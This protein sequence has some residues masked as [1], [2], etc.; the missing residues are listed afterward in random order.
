MKI[1]CHII[2]TFGRVKPKIMVMG[3]KGHGKDTVCEMLRDNH[4]YKFE[5]SSYFALHNCG[6]YEILKGRHGYKTA[7]ECY[8][9]RDNHR[10]E[11]HQLIKDFNTQDLAK[12]GR[13]IYAD[14]DIYCG[15]RDDEE[16]GELEY[17]GLIDFK[18]WVDSSARGKPSENRDSC[19]VSAEDS[20]IIL[21]NF[22]SLKDL[23][24]TISQIVE[25]IENE[26]NSF[27]NI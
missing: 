9:D 23:K 2:E 13:M 26:R 14:N 16:L 22:G 8:L 3:Y 20:D 17:E 6:L 5:S 1:D 18:I 4:G 27:G 15:I 24:V 10:P 19:K 21:E 7:Q 12:M 11:W 25:D